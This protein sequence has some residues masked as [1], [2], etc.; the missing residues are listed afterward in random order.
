MCLKAVRTWRALHMNHKVV[1]GWASLCHAGVPAAGVQQRGT[2]VELR[3]EGAVPVSSRK[4]S[5]A[6]SI[7]LVQALGHGGGALQLDAAGLSCEAKLHV[8]QLG[9]TPALQFADQ[10]CLLKGQ[11]RPHTRRGITVFEHSVHA[12]LIKMFTNKSD[13]INHQREIHL[14]VSSCIICRRTKC[15]EWLHTE[16]ILCA[17]FIK[18][19][20]LVFQSNKELFPEIQ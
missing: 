16:F 3:A 5:E 12:A 2:V 4:H 8:L 19:N 11:R 1:I 20:K 18:F 17:G 14:S 6:G 9:Q 10:R 7:G 15:A 13:F